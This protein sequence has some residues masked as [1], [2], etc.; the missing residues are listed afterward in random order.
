MLE[1]E[2]FNLVK[3]HKE[4]FPNSPSFR[5]INPPKSEIGKTSKPNLDNIKKSLLLKTKL[6]QWENNSGTITWFEN[7]SY[8][9]PEPNCR[10]G[11]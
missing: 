6:N 11:I 4:G 9:S 1:L 8:Y 2:A 5:L 3:H 7:I 10:G